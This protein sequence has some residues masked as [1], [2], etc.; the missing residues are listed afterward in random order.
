MAHVTSTKDVPYII[1]PFP[2]SYFYSTTRKTTQG[3]EKKRE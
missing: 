1:S 2:Y 3:D